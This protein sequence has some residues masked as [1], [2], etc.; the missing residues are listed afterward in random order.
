MVDQFE[1]LKDIP[2]KSKDL[3]CGFI[4][5]TEKEFAKNMIIPPLIITICILFYDLGECFTIWGDNITVEDDFK[6]IK[7]RANG[8]AYAYV[9]NTAYGNICINHSDGENVLIF[10]H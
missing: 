3:V 4:R 1:K 8:R 2:Q 10:I 5:R 9:R 7:I 6:T